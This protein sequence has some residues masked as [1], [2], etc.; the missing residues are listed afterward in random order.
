MCASVCFPG[1]PSS[2]SQSSAGI[3]CAQRPEPVSTGACGAHR[4]PRCSLKFRGKLPSL[5]MFL[6]TYLLMYVLRQSKRGRDRSSIS[7]VV[8]PMATAVWNSTGSPRRISRELDL[9]GDSWDLN[10]PSSRGCQHCQQQLS[11]LHQPLPP[12]SLKK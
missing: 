8:P 4:F 5:H 7:G 1:R 6:K 2:A 10:L 11:L 3:P 12:V 9:E